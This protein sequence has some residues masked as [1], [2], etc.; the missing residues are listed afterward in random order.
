MRLKEAINLFLEYLEIEKGRS[1]KT[2]EN[3]RRYLLKF[4]KFLKNFLKKPE[5]DLK[6]KDINL[7]LIRKF[8]LYLV[9]KEIKRKTQSYYLITLRNFLKYLAK[10]DIQCVPPEKIELP[11]NESYEI[12]VISF[13]ELERL[14][15]AP[16]GNSLKDLRDK[17]I[18]ELIF[19]CGLRVSEL[20]T[21]NRDQINLNLD[22]FPV[23]GKGGKIRLVFLS[24]YAKNALK[25][26]LE[27]RKDICQALFITFSGKKSPKNF[28]R[29]TPRTVQRIIEYWRKKAGIVKKVTP[30]TLRHMF[31]TD[32]LQ[33]GADLRAI[34]MLLGHSNISTTQIYTHLADKTLKEVHQTFHAKR[35][36]K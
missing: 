33:N 29:I 13:E 20:C 3:Y 15:N 6:V 8:R 7:N 25:K 2:I 32:L 19:S 31:A 10:Q 30:H 22:E 21:L 23:K 1:K 18:M 17:A 9:S 12:K 16:K 34:Q 24:K 27:A 35:R 26:Y 11:K 14:L 5:R 4:L 36:K 28:R